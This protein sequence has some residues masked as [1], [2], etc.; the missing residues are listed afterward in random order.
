MSHSHVVTLSLCLALAPLVAGRAQRASGDT[1]AGAKI[2]GA[3][4][5][6]KRW[7]ALVDSNRYAASWDSAASL[8][9]QQIP[10]AA[11]QTA[12]TSARL[13]V[14]PLGPRRQSGAQ[15]SRQLS[16]APP[17]E[18]VLLQFATMARGN[19]QCTET[20]ALARDTDGAWRVAG[21]FIKPG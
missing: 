21:Y 5:A 13:Q 3:E 12:V 15:Y 10:R 18:Y 6:A 9:R 20:V 19:I 4:A 7:L 8:F 16:N 1:S 14:D 11:W 17:G 2:E